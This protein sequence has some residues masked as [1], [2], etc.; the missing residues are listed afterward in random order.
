MQ[1]SKSS[2]IFF[3]LENISSTIEH[4][5][6]IDTPYDYYAAPYTPYRDFSNPFWFDL[7]FFRII[8]RHLLSVS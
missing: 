2:R 3:K 5:I 1:K 6:N 8:I 4:L 7:E